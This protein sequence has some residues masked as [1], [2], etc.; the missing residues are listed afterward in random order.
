MVISQFKGC[1]MSAT[2]RELADQVVRARQKAWDK[3]D[4]TVAV[5]STEQLNPDDKVTVRRLVDAEGYTGKELDEMVRK[6]SALVVGQVEAL[7]DDMPTDN[8]A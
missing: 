3:S 6:V 2:A 8:S 7:A 1:T 5:V 4:P